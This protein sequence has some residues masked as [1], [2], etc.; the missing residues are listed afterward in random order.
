MG[1]NDER[2]FSTLAAAAERCMIDINSRSLANT[3]FPF[4]RM[5]VS[6]QRWKL[7]L[8]RMMDFNSQNLANTAWAFATVGHKDEGLFSTLAAAAERRMRDFNLQNFANTA[9]I[10]GKNDFSQQCYIA[11]SVG[12]RGGP[13]PLPNPPRTAA[14]GQ[15]FKIFFQ[16]LG[17]IILKII[18]HQDYFTTFLPKYF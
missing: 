2:L 3:A 12:R 15:V 14:T 5:N 17:K 16:D 1:H 10:D 6:C 7:L 4:A 11:P 13:P 8:W 9:C 18:V